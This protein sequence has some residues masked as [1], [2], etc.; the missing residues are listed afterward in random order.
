MICI[1]FICIYFTG[2]ISML[3]SKLPL[4]LA[5]LSLSAC[6]SY[7]AQPVVTS[8]EERTAIAQYA[9]PPAAKPYFEAIPETPAATPVRK[10]Q[11]TANKNTNNG[12]NVILLHRPH[13]TYYSSPVVLIR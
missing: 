12:R 7:T 11:T 10:K 2:V 6:V 4:L 13:R 8:A 3:P 9:P 5:A 1:Y